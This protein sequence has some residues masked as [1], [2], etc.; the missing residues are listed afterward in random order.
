MSR[1]LINGV[2][3]VLG[4][5]PEA[6]RPGLHVAH[7]LVTGELV[8]LALPGAAGLRPRVPDLKLEGEVFADIASPFVHKIVDWG[9]DEVFVAWEYVS[10]W[11]LSTV[12]AMT[13]RFEISAV[14]RILHDAASGLGA[15]HARGA[16]YRGLHPGKVMVARDGAARLGTTAAAVLTVRGRVVEAGPP[17]E[18]PIHYLSPEQIEGVIDARS[19]IYTLAAVGYELLAGSPMYTTD[20]PVTL[21]VQ[22]LKTS[23]PPPSKHRPDA[24]PEL[25]DLFMHCLDRDPDER[26]ASVPAFLAHVN[27]LLESYDADEPEPH[28]R[29]ITSVPMM[30]P[31]PT[32]AAS[33]VAQS[34][35]QATVGV[36]S[37]PLSQLPG[38]PSAEPVEDVAADGT[39]SAAVG[40]EVAPD[41]AVA[42]A[43]QDGPVRMVLVAP[44][45]EIFP[46]R[47][48]EARIGRP[49]LAGRPPEVNLDGLDHQRVVS[50]DHAR[51]ERKDGRWYL[52]DLGA[53]NGTWLN[54]RQLEDGELAALTPGDRLRIANVDLEVRTSGD[55]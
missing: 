26:P 1:D 42:A 12:A 41:V 53:T 17:P 43:G 31:L 10:V 44:T 46:L 47:G 32:A 19:D 38:G 7:S 9:T 22:I 6:G 27:K 24:T 28:G 11:S 37:P 3:R 18:T 49:D 8:I 16:V 30:F 34:A 54:D 29:A 51:L 48:A 15:V 52:R 13:G 45:G 36:D 14:L 23:P 39:A 4:A 5:L 33:G 20:D 50:R 2:Y 55:I 25:D 40:A 21:A 35:R